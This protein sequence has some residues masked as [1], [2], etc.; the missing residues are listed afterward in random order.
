MATKKK[1]KADRVFV[2]PDGEKYNIVGETGKYILCENG[3]QFR[4]SA[5]RGEVV[6]LPHVSGEDERKPEKEQ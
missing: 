6:N 1:A 4:K 2:L 5:K 3:I